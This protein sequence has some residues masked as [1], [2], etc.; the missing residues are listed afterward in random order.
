[1]KESS[2]SLANSKRPSPHIKSRIG[3]RRSR[4]LLHWGGPFPMMDQQ[5]FF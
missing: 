1:M 5:P 3:I 4:F 2:K